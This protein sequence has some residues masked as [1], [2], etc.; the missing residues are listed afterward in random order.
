ML[1]WFSLEG[2]ILVRREHEVKKEI[3]IQYKSLRLKLETKKG[4]FASS[5]KNI[6]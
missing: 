5:T 1:S 6:L 2:S 3:E 4:K